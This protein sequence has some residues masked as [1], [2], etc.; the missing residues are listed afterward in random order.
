MYRIFSL[1]KQEYIELSELRFAL[2]S[3][4]L[5]YGFER[6][7]SELIEGL[8]ST[9]HSMKD[10]LKIT[11]REKY[12]TLDNNFHHI[13]FKS[14]G[15]SAITKVYDKHQS[16]IVA[17]RLRNLKKENINKKTSYEQHKQ[18]VD[19]LINENID[20]AIML[21]EKHI[22]DYARDSFVEPELI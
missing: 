17:T 8:K 19:M 12:Q 4:A 22:V 14:C 15:N 6:N 10:F 1:S 5:R 20:Q 18:L 7:R 16:V 3:Q 9:L 21:L 2:E 13:F 11:D